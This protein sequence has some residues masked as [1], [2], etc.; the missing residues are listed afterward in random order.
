MTVDTGIIKITIGKQ[1]SVSI[2]S[3]VSTPTP[4]LDY[5]LRHK[6]E[7]EL[8]KEIFNKHYDK[9]DEYYDW[10]RVDYY[11][12]KRLE[13]NQELRNDMERIHQYENIKRHEEYYAYRYQFYIGTLV[14]CYI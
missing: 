1:V 10:K 12:K 9:I 13:R 3:S 2:K 5:T 14:D 6:H 7:I 8:R 11:E 4:L